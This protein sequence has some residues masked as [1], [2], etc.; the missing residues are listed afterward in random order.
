MVQAFRL[1]V[2]LLSDIS[3]GRFAARL[4]SSSSPDVAPGPQARPAAGSANKREPHLTQFSR[5]VRG[6]AV[7]GLLTMASVS[8]VLSTAGMAFDPVLQCVA[9]LLGVATGGILGA[10][11]AA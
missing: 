3:T 2:Y 5:I 8:V 6:G 4:I 7:I 1:G 10:R 9:G 11:D